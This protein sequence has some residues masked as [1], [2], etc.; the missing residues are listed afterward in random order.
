MKS[1]SNSTPSSCTFLIAITLLV[2]SRIFLSCFSLVATVSGPDTAIDS[3]A[4]LLPPKGQNQNRVF[5]VVGA[6]ADTSRYSSVF[7]S[8]TCGS[9]DVSASEATGLSK[10][11][12]LYPPVMA[13]G[14]HGSSGVENTATNFLS[15]WRIKQQQHIVNKAKSP[16][17]MYI[18]AP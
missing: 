13:N 8:I 2:E 11:N 18:S 14:S 9:K 3:L 1:S 12:S 4:L 16:S 15:M 6:G 17:C 5:L 10:V 7:K